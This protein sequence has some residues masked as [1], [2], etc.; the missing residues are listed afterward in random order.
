MNFYKSVTNL[1]SPYLPAGAV[2]RSGGEDKRD[3]WA[4]GRQSHTKT[5]R[6]NSGLLPDIVLITEVAGILSSVLLRINQEN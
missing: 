1:F 4:R 5:L 3:D 6:V 2:D